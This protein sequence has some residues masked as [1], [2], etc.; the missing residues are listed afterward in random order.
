MYNS[1][2]LVVLGFTFLRKIIIIILKS[3]VLL[4]IYAAHRIEMPREY[5]HPLYRCSNARFP[6]QFARVQDAYTIQAATL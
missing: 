1:Q 4:N 2:T 6:N 3:C 5:H